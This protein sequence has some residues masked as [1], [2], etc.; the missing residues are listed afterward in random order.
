[1]RNC[2]L[3]VLLLASLASAAPP[4]PGSGVTDVPEGVS[5]GR[6]VV[7]LTGGDYDLDADSTIRICALKV[8][9]LPD[10]TETTSGS[11]EFETGGAEIALLMEQF[12]DYYYDVSGG[13]LVLDITLYPADDSAFRVDHQMAYY[14]ADRKNGKGQCELLRDAVNAADQSVDFSQYGAVIVIHAGAGQESDIRG[15]SPDDIHS[16]F[17]NS[18][19]LEHYLGTPSVITDDGVAV[20]E[21]CI[22]PETETQDNYG[23]GVLGTIAHEFGH[24]LGLPDLYNT[25][26]GS[27]GI[28]G[29]DL[30]GYGQWLMNGFWPAAPGAWSRMFLKWES[31]EIIAPGTY[32]AEQEGTVYRIPLTS[33]E[34]LLLENRQRDPDGDGQCG[35]HDRDY[36]L[37]GSGLLIWHVDETRLGPY[38][39][40]NRVNVDPLHKGVDVEEADGI[41]DL[42][43]GFPTWFSIE[44]S[45]FDPWKT[46]GYAWEFTP[47][48]TPSTDASWGGTTGVSVEVTTPS[49][50]TM[51][52]IYSLAG[53]VPGWPVS[54]SGCRFGPVFWSP[55]EGEFVV[56]V[57]GNRQAIAISSDGSDKISAGLNLT[58]PPVVCNT[59]GKEYLV[60]CQADGS[61][62][63]RLPDWTEA[64]GWPFNA[65]SP[66][67]QATVATGQNRI[68]LIT[69]DNLLYAL[70]YDGIQCNG[71]PTSFSLPLTGGCVYPDSENPGFVLVSADGSLRRTGPGGGT[72]FGWPV[73]PGTED[74]AMPFAADID[75]DGD[76]E[77]VAAADGK[78]WSYSSDSSLEPGFPVEVQGEILSDPFPADVDSDGYI[79]TVIE[80]TKG[81]EAFTSS[82]TI[83]TDWPFVTETDSLVYQYKRHS[84]GIGGD[85]FLVA[86]LRDGRTV[87]LQEGYCFAFGDQPAG[88]PVLHRFTGEDSYRLMVTA[89]GGSTGA[90]YTDFIPQGWHTGMDRGGERCWYAQDLPPVASR[91]NLLSEETFFVWP[92]PVT[93]DTGYIRF[94]PGSDADYTIRIFNIAG[95]LAGE[96]SGSAPGGVPWEVNWNTE[97]L[98]PGVYYVCLELNSE[99]TV[100]EALFQA[101]VVN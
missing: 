74:A 51:E 25:E 15:N 84:S 21:G 18:A 95:E 80:T 49:Q 62:H 92:N 81:L 70:N 40:A 36:G 85:G 27:V 96:F 14:G 37:P 29:W 4:V 79:E 101:A 90:F 28:G 1:M 19:N 58:A 44:G 54:L 93:A 48:S 32:A 100:A 43:Y 56:V 68:Y 77:V 35:P 12:A 46:D 86:P 87:I 33:T 64:P 7:S 71:S 72:I 11:G 88:R 26:T 89:A 39:Q 59:G 42:D 50:N 34:Y 47:S 94:E 10:Y 20:R 23:L 65:G 69:E 52:F 3:S 97:D 83:A 67:T 38:K 73:H 45:E 41:Q 5:D 76:V 91:D 24:Q 22:N 30:M 16:M 31:P 61:V 9:F 75:R 66:V 6:A 2:I 55:P 13:Q 60:V 53:V 82:G 99:G 8:E 98:A 17:I 63:L 57:R 78:I